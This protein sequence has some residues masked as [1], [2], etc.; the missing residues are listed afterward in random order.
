[1]STTQPPTRIAIWDN[2]R[3]ILIALVVLGHAISPM[4]NENIYLGGLY[5]FIYTFHMPAMLLVSALFIKEVNTTM[6]TVGKNIIGIFSVWVFVEILWMGYRFLWGETA[7][8]SSAFVVPSWTMWFLVTLFTLR[9][10]LPYILWFKHP[11]VLSSV[12]ALVAGFSPF[13]GAEFSASRTLTFLPFFVLGYQ[14]RNGFSAGSTPLFQ[15][16]W[17]SEGVPRWA[18]LSSLAILASLLVVFV[19]NRREE[20]FESL[21]KWLLWKDSYHDLYDNIWLAPAIKAGLLLLALGMLF[22]AFLATPR[23]F[24]PLQI[25]GSNTMT[26]YIL[27]GFILYGIAQSEILEGTVYEL[28]T[29]WLSLFFAL[30]SVAILAIG[31]FKP[32]VALVKPVLDPQWLARFSSVRKQ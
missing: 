31:S 21:T 23:K 13:I 16:R 11:L 2:Y 28:P 25:V 4:R 22:L 7:V 12:I 24:A 6:E 5:D 15:H 30:L 20:W 18:S 32:F 27:H 9:L 10:I 19:L 29:V 26:I 17:V 14:L 1:M 8:R 3:G